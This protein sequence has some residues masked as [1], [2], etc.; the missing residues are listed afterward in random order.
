MTEKPGCF[1]VPAVFSFTSRVCAKCERFNQCQVEAHSSL[2]A[3]PVTIVGKV[4]EQHNRYCHANG[5]SV[6]NVGNVLITSMPT[7]RPTR[8]PTRLEITAEQQAT[9]DALPKKTGDYLRKLIVRGVDKEVLDAAE[10]GENAFT[11]TKHRPYRV[12]LDMLLEGGIT[13]PALRVAYCDQLGWSKPAA[14]SQVSM[15]W[16]LFPAM[17]L[18]EE[19]GASLMPLPNIRCKNS[20]I[21]TKGVFHA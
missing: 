17:R 20:S 8:S 11:M 4:L 3:A 13:K 6:P 2:L 9:I 10:R 21:A 16:G 19:R 14:F 7:V 15:V 18:A 1:G 12:A 5:L